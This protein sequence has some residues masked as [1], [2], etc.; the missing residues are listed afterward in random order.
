[1]ITA[2]EI[3]NQQSDADK[4]KLMRDLKGRFFQGYI[5]PKKGKKCP[6][7][8]RNI[9][10]EC[11]ICHKQFFVNKCH[12]YAK[13]CSKRCT[14]QGYNKLHGISN[15][16]YEHDFCQD[17]KIT[18]NCLFCHLN[19]EAQNIMQ[20][21]CSILCRQRFYRAEHRLK[22]R[23]ASKEYSKKDNIKHHDKK[24]LRRFA[25]GNTR[26]L[27]FFKLG[28]KCVLCHEVATQIH[29]RR[30]TK[31]W[32]DCVPVCSVCHGIL[33]SYQRKLLKMR[34]ESDNC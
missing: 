23:I 27:I 20:R 28:R 13:F 14:K 6:Q 16:N 18:K 4:Q 25:Y 15:K 10:K 5:S 32:R 19:F 3:F 30:Y 34:S 24:L 31:N 22:I 12:S 8:N 7:G 21:F 17:G 2:K 1:M 26:Q 33:N 11:E 9:E 29:H